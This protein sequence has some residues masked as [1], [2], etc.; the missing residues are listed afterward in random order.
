M[1]YISLKEWAKNFR[2][3]HPHIK[4]QYQTI[5]KWARTG[6]IEGAEKMLGHWYVRQEG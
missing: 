4:V 1:E 5:L 6:K 2:A 3:K